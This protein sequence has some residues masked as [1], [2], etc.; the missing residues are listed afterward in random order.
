MS[1]DREAMKGAALL[2]APW[3]LMLGDGSKGSMPVA[4]DQAFQGL[5]AGQVIASPRSDHS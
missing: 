3:Q 2:K 1:T 5:S 4:S